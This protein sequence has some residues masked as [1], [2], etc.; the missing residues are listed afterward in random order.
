MPRA[1]D[2]L[3]PRQ[4]QDSRLP[5]P[6][7][8]SAPLARTWTH[9]SAW[10]YPRIR[11]RTEYSRR[12]V[13][14]ASPT[15]DV[16]HTGIAVPDS[17]SSCGCSARDMRWR[18]LPSH[19][20]WIPAIW[21][22]MGSSRGMAFWFDSLDSGA[23]AQTDSRAARSI[24]SSTTAS[25]F[26]QFWCCTRGDSVGRNIAFANKALFAMFA[27]FLCSALWS[28]FPLPTV[29]RLVQ[30]FGWVLVAPIILT[31]RDPAA[32]MR[33]VFVRVSYILFPLVPD[34]H[35]VLSRA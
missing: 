1:I 23:V 2:E 15:L 8:L 12:V 28:P 4:N 9:R 27:F 34:P 6:S 17:R 16:R 18:R 32:A 29:K 24:S 26:W 13:A 22:A 5:R 21:L 20:L 33:V 11:S 7:I 19:A 10:R 31:E 14:I 3:I 30:E 35:A 25:F